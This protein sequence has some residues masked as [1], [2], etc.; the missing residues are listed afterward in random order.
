MIADSFAVTWTRLMA[1]TLLLVAA[2]T[3]VREGPPARLSA[4][5]FSSDATPPIGH[6]LAGTKI[7]PAEVIE[8][9]LLLKGVVLQDGDTRYVLAALDWCTLSD[10]AYDTF[11]R[12]IAAAAGTSPS[13]VAVHCTHTHSGPAGRPSDELLSRASDAAQKAVREALPEMRPFTHVGV[14]KARVENFASN[15]RV[16]GKDGKILVR[17][18]STK[19]AALRAEPEGLIDPWLRTVTLF[20]G[21]KP[22]VRM[23]YYASHPQ[24]FY[25]DG[26]VHPDTPGWARARLEKEEGVPHLY[27]T[28]CGG[29]VTAGKYNDGSPEARAG[30]IERL[31]TGMKQSLTDTR[32]A[33]IQAI[34]WKTTEV[35]F[36]WR[37][38]EKAPE[39]SEARPP[40][41]L[42]CLTLGPAEVLHLPGE[43][44]VEYQ[45]YAQGLRTDRFI[46]VAGY[47]NG[48]PGYICTDKALS[49]G[50]Y[51]PTASRVVPPSEVL[52]KAAIAKLLK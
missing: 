51:E 22:L 28:G 10:D 35:R 2:C 47:G 41:E 43:P 20:D 9:P 12:K 16:P 4:A 37:T 3:P 1:A 31:V 19:D 39:P 42:S 49:E 24:S 46:A 18:S 11:R 29:N 52:L 50:G 5:A 7:K 27:F 38:D 33:P 25:G 23:H 21:E 30:L 26:H 13:K 15:R 45:L 44:F 17:Y 14:G 8:G 6:W 36:A 34:G 40:I 32:R 48:S